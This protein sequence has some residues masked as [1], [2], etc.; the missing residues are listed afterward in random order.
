MASKPKPAAACTAVRT[1]HDGL[2]RRPRER[3]ERVAHVPPGDGVVGP[4]LLGERLG[5]GFRD[6][7]AYAQHLS[8]NDVYAFLKWVVVVVVVLVVDTAVKKSARNRGDLQPED[9]FSLR[10]SATTYM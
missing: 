7:A 8:A 9:P 4:V 5:W 10:I 6:D 3:L 2:R 1:E